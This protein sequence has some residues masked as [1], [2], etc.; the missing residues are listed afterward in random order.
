MK[1]GFGRLTQR[2]GRMAKH[3]KVKAELMQPDFQRVK[4]TILEQTHFGREFG[5][6][7][8]HEPSKFTY[9]KFTLES[10]WGTVGS[11]GYVSRFD[12]LRRPEQI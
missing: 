10:R 4:V 7:D 2:G 11:G 9:S 6:E 5:K 12:V 1:G 3:L 8:T